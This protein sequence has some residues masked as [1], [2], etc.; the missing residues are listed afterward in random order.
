MIVF[1]AWGHLPSSQCR[2]KLE[3]LSSNLNLEWLLVPLISDVLIASKRR[4]L[5]SVPV[6]PFFEVPIS[7]FF[8][9]SD[10]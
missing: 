8:R 6:S 1:K 9:S 2:G 3:N 4:S 7:V 5:N 10:H